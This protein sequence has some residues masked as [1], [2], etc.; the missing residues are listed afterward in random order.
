MM[1]SASVL[2]APSAPLTTR[3]EETREM[4]APYAKMPT[5]ETLRHRL[6][7]DPSAGIFRWRNPKPRSGMR[8]GDIAG[9]VWANGYRYITLDE[10]D[11]R[12]ARLAWL[13]VHGEPV[14]AQLDHINR[15][16]DDDRIANLRPTDNSRNQANRR[17]PKNNTSGVKGVHWD[18]LWQRWRA[19]IWVEGHQFVIGGFHTKAEA[20]AAYNEAARKAFGDH[21]LK[22]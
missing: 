8:A 20:A 19:T 12:A 3:T 11:Y 1:R 17:A 22:E 10:V 21:A 16:K 6:G 15:I 18:R 5:Q 13:W 14:P 7:Y 2:P 9:S 4:A